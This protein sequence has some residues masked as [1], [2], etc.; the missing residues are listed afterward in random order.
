MAP[1]PR[2]PGCCPSLRQEGDGMYPLLSKH[3]L[4]PTFKSFS[5]PM[6][7]PKH[8]ASDWCGWLPSCTQAPPPRGP[9]QQQGAGESSGEPGTRSWNPRGRWAGRARES[10]NRTLAARERG[11]EWVEEGGHQ[12]EGERDHVPKGSCCPVTMS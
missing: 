1:L 12:V 4:R 5:W 6:P 10:A 2:F 3:S 8:A 9:A 11:R 7:S